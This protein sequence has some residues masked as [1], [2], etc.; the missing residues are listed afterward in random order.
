MTE[1]RFWV[2]RAARWA[3]LAVAIAMLLA[4]RASAA[5][6]P[7]PREL[8]DYGG[9]GGQPTTPGKVLLWGPRVVFFPLYVVSEY[10]VRRPLGWLITSAERAQVPAALY[11]FFAFGPEHKAGFVP[12]AFV[13]FGFRPSVGIYAFW[14]DAGFSGHDLRLHVSTGGNNWFAG[15]VTERF[16]LGHDDHLTLDV[17]AGRRPDYAY[18]GNGP[19]TSTADRGR[20]GADKVDARVAV[21]V[22]IWRSSRI[23]TAVGFRSA[24]FRPGQYLGQPTLEDRA[25]AGTFPLPDGYGEGYRAGFSR[26]KIVLDSRRPA[27]ESRSGGRL[28]LE[29]EQGTDLQQ[30]APS[31]WLRYGGAVG[32]FLDLGDNGRVVSLSVSTVFAEPIGPRPVPFTELATLG[33]PGL[34]PGFATGRLRD[35]SA[36]VA[37][38]RY[39]WPIWVWLQGSLQTAVGNVFAEHLDGLRPSL[40]RLSAAVGIESE[41]S[42][43][44]TFQILFGFG[45]ETFDRGARI[46]SLRLTLGARHGF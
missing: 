22:G 38:L 41:G 24:T 20:Y 21:D 19:L 7:E 43:D 8:P 17:S 2:S 3:S 33:G 15:N 30:A 1:S 13:E 39:S 16:R 9:R 28:E 11:D 42:R 45:T 29:G 32:G 36:A 12:V 37:T 4:G 23:E 25:S 27:S 35:R 14:D 31:G 34:M 18:F 10:V 40:L 44:S 6:S 5:T 46:D 26:L